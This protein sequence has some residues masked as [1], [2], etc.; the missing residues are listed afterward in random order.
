MRT[1]AN[2]HIPQLDGTVISRRRNLT[3]TRRVPDKLLYTPDMTQQFLTA[4]N[5]RAIGV[6]D[7]DF[8]ARGCG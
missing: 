5:I 2:T 6:P 8:G 4:L 1:R 7:A 3:L